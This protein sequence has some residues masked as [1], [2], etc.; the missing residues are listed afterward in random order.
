MSRIKS[1]LVL[2]TLLAAPALA[3]A[4][5][6]AEPPKWSYIE[7]GYIDF[8]PDEGDSDNGAYA[9]GSMKLFKNF[10]LVAEYDDIGDVTF[11][12]GGFGWHGLLG[13]KADLYAQAVWANIDVN[14]SD[15]SED[16]YQLQGGVR[17]KLIRWFELKLQ[18]NYSDYGGDVGSDT[19]GEV[20]ALFVFFKDR[21]GVGA[22]WAGGGDADTTR[23][24]LRFNFGR[25]K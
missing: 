16:G 9:L 19:T 15:I 6:Q 10:H 13:D 12:N 8:S 5:G 11:W 20:G 7:V 2:I 4:A 17:W 22:D 23:A 3:L 18:A 24:F 14:D 25:N 21:M 1:L